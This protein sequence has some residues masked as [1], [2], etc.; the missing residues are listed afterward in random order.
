MACAVKAAALLPRCPSATR[1][2]ACSVMATD[3]TRFQPMRVSY[4]SVR[5]ADDA[6][7]RRV[8]SAVESDGNRIGLFANS[9]SGDGTC[10]G[11]KPSAG[12]AALCI[13]ICMQLSCN[14]LGAVLDYGPVMR[15]AAPSYSL[16]A[17][18]ACKQQRKSARLRFRASLRPAKTLVGTACSPHWQLTRGSKKIQRVCM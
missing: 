5:H 8:A 14:K 6:C 10:F 16:P 11:A 9:I 7:W 15:L 3:A 13:C 4:I 12:Q 17:S 18:A 2:S 1:A